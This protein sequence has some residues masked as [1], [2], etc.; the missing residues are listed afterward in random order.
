MFVHIIH[1]IQTQEQ[2]QKAL[3]INRTPNKIYVHRILKAIY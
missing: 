3:N 2:Q 1:Q